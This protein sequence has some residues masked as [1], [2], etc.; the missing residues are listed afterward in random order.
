MDNSLR[1]ALV[2]SILPAIAGVIGGSTFFY[3]PPTPGLLGGVRKLAAGAIIGVMAFELL[4]DLLYGHSANALLVLAVGGGVMFSLRWVTR[5]FSAFGWDAL[6]ALVAGLLIG[7]SFVAGFRE[8]ILLITVFTVVAVAIGLFAAS[9]MS[10]T[11]VAHNRAI[12]MI[13]LLAVLIV[14]GALVGGV[15]I[16][17]PTGIDLDL[18][19]VFMMASPL[20]WA[21]E[22][23]VETEGEYATDESLIFFFVGLVLFLLLAWWLGGKHSDHPGRRTKAQASTQRDLKETMNETFPLGARWGG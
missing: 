9:V 16:D 4:P 6:Q 2:F 11:G 1:N 14:V 8:G 19:F 3:R 13:V 22:G 17:K 7:S 10:R 12:I 20:L 21:M 18:T 5:K 23:L 15:T